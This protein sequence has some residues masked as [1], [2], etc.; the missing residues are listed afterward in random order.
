MHESYNA[1]NLIVLQHIQRFPVEFAT[2]FGVAEGEGAGN[3]GEFAVIQRKVLE[4]LEVL[5]SESS[6]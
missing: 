3:L 1:S 2:G 5:W 4:E 6:T